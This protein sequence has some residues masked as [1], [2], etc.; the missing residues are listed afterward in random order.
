MAIDFFNSKINSPGGFY[1]NSIFLITHF[2]DYGSAFH[3]IISFHSTSRV[4]L[5][6]N[7]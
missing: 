4:L 5:S 1:F 3:F 6:L 2:I 7:N